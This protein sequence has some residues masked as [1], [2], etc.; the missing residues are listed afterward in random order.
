MKLLP[1]LLCLIFA[2]GAAARAGNN[3][4]LI[5]ADDYGIDSSS[6]YN[7]T[8][9]A[10]LP[11]TPNINALASNGVRFT[12]AYA[13]PVC[14]PS[15][16][17]LITGRHGFRPGVG[18]AVTATAGNSLT[19]AELTLAEVV[20]QNSGLGI[21]TACFGKWHLSIGPGTPNSPNTIGGWPHYSGSTGGVLASYT[22][23]AKVVNGAQSTSTTYATTDVVND[24]AAWIG[25]RNA[26]GQKWVAW[27]AFNAPHTPF[28][29]PPTGL[30]SYGASPATN[31][32]KYEAAVESMDTEI[33]RLLLA[34]NTG[35]TDIIFMGDNGTPGMVV[36]PPYTSAHAK[37]TLYEGGIRV[38]LIVRGPSV[39]SPGRT[40]SALVH[41]VDIYKT[42]LELAGVPL[43]TTVTLDSRSL[44]T[45]LENQTDT[46]RTRLYTEQFDQ[47]AA[48]V[49]GR[50]LRDD[51]Y[52]LI[53]LNNGTEEFYDLSTD[54]NEATNL[55]AG[56]AAAM[57][58]ERQSYYHR[59]RFELGRYTTATAPTATSAGLNAGAF[60]VTVPQNTGATQTL[61]RCTDLAAGF[62]APAP[63]ATSVTGG[64]SITFTDP[65][66][67]ASAAYYSVLAE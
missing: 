17:C 18:E 63:G 38:P 35:T 25:A 36:Q 42:M 14:S 53:R 23:W 48:T 8:A 37:D 49:G 62:W 2:A 24:A 28:H 65:A 52:K 15:R 45:I 10:T 11:P 33:G 16:A 57:T 3:V 30:H 39:V 60:S 58:A 9:G 6:L 50:V 64:A 21:Q 54:T 27:V 61:W 41:A 22:S 55:I 56:G 5:I 12:N 13:N 34:V 7:S 46:A 19:T 20:S 59:L 67:P 4:L 1:L 47:S 31:R 44:K 66:P 26:A 29:N 51:R 32:L 40:S 43:P